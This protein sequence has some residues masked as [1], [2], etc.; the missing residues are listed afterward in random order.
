MKKCFVLGVGAQKSGTTWLY[1]YLSN[2]VS[3]NF[4]PHKEYH[5]WDALYIKECYGF[6]AQ[7]DDRLRYHLQ[8][9]HGAYE[10]YFS[11]L[12]CDGINLTG[13]ITPSYSGLPADC[14]RLIRRRIESSG[15]DLKVIFLMRDPF[16][17]CWSAVRHS[18]RDRKGS[19]QSAEIDELRLAYANVHFILRTNYKHTIEALESAFNRKQIYYGIYEE[20]FA[21]QKIEE[22]SEFIGVHCNPDFGREQLNVAPKLNDEALSL[23]SE[24][25]KFYSDVYNF[26]FERFPQTKSLL[27]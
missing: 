26:C 24:I 7:K 9:D 18:R 15:F 5:I 8:N 25:R 4:G 27:I 3:V 6:I 19:V 20:L 16:E 2:D 14:F 17:R 10:E 11:S 21:L 22:I 13:D 12:I 1:K 23:K